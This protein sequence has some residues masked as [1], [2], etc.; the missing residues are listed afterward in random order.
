MTARALNDASCSQ[1]ETGPVV[2][3]S[4]HFTTCGVR[5]RVF[6]PHPSATQ[7]NRAA[8]LRTLCVRIFTRESPCK[9][10][11]Y[12]PN[13]VWHAV[14]IVVACDVYAGSYVSA[15]RMGATSKAITA[16]PLG[17]A[18]LASSRNQRL[19]TSAEGTGGC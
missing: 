16:F 7:S 5:T 1:L 12:A 13:F 9:C 19:S 3:L 17:H 15:G 2:F 11:A 4:S 18:F 8:Q 6:P 10:R 14:C